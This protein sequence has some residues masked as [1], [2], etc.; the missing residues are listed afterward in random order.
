[1]SK[2]YDNVHQFKS[3]YYE[4]KVLT[5]KDKVIDVSSDE[6]LLEFIHSDIT[7]YVVSDIILKL[8][9]R[10]KDFKSINIIKLFDSVGLV[11]LENNKFYDSLI[12]F[13]KL[14]FSNIL[15]RIEHL[16]GQR[17]LDDKNRYNKYSD[18]IA[19]QNTFK[20][21]DNFVSDKGLVNFTEQQHNTSKRLI[22]DMTQVEIELRDLLSYV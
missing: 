12:P 1:M 16:V 15:R 5:Y 3:V 17:I 14:Y 4:A 7:S 11:G 10:K 19:F 2:S 20:T 18:I 8:K 13:E 6:K 22:E 9:R 21:F